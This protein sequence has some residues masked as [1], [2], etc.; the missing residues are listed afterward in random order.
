MKNKIENVIPFP[1]DAQSNL[2]FCALTSVLLAV[3]EAGE[4]NNL[5]FFCEQSTACCK[6]CNGCTRKPIPERRHLILYHFLSTVTGVSLLW[7]DPAKTSTYPNRFFPGKDSGLLADRLDF[8]LKACGCHYTR[9]EKGM[10]KAEIFTEV[11]DSVNQG[12]PVLVKLGNGEDWHIVT[13]YSADPFTFYGIDAHKHYSVRP[14]VA[15]EGYLE[16]GCFYLSDWYPV[17]QCAVAV[18]DLKGFGLPFYYLIQRMHFV[19]SREESNRLEAEIFSE[20]DS[21]TGPQEPGSRLYH[22]VRYALEGRWHA[23]ECCKFMLRTMT[24]NPTQ[25]KCLA[26]ITNQ[27]L[28]FH[29]I[30]WNLWESIG[31]SPDTPFVLPEHSNEILQQASGKESLKASVAI[32]F[33]IDRSVCQLLQ[34]IL[35]SSGA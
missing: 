18:T 31:A 15:P 28:R 9:L 1:V 21:L 5:R 25:Q 20:I 14:A 35:N 3:G 29:K 11:A 13:G 10:R 12:I 7:A 34:I 6:D 2:L 16:D 30:C 8:A 17:F 23:A 27:Y 19:L 33:E 26:E 22:L 4:G 24:T 32:L